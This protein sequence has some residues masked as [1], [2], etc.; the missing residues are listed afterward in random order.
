MLL[1]HLS[2]VEKELLSK[3]PNF[4][5]KQCNNTKVIEEMKVGFQKLIHDV[6]W[7]YNHTRNQENR[8]MASQP[9]R[10][11]HNTIEYP[12]VTDRKEIKLP[13][14]I[15][16]VEGV[17]KSCHNKYINV[18]KTIEKRRIHGNLRPDERRAIKDINERGLKIVASDKG[19]DL[20]IVKGADYIKA[21]NEHLDSNQIY[22]R[23]SLFKIEKLE[24]RVNS[25]WKSVCDRNKIPQSVKNMYMSKCC[26]F[27]TINAV[28][29]TH[30]SS[31]D[32][33]VVRPIVNSIGSP[34]Y[35]LSKF[36]QKVI[37][38]LVSENIVSSEVIMNRI[39]AVDQTT[40]RE[41][42]FPVSLDV[43]SMF[44]NIPRNI[45][46]DFLHHKLNET[47][48]NL[49]AIPP[50]D[51]IKLIEICLRCNH[52]KHENKLYFQREALPMGNR[53]SGVVAEIFMMN[54][55]SEIYATIE[56]PPPTFRYVDD[57]LIFTTG[58]EETNQIHNLYNNN[59]Y[60]LK[61]A[62]ELPVNNNLPFL[63]FRVR[64]TSE[65]SAQFEFFRKSVRKDNFVSANTALP[66]RTI[67]NIIRNERSRIQ[68]R[69]SDIEFFK[70]QEIVFIKR[71]SRN[72]HD[73][74]AQRFFD[75]QFF[76]NRLANDYSFNSLT[77][78][79]DATSNKV[80]FLNI[81]FVDDNIERK[82]KQA[83]KELGVK[84]VVSHKGSQLKH[85]MA[86]NKRESSCNLPN[87]KLKSPLCLLNGSVY[88]IKGKKMW[89]I[90]HWFELASS[91]HTI[92]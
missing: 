4:S 79:R 16:E 73:L 54:F 87:C 78:N 1:Y 82:I 31:V 47:E 15:P 91:A 23:V 46:L 81:P 80:F 61:F 63:D 38:P 11:A 66:A 44:H 13:P 32:S 84:I 25:V 65:G 3:G 8:E 75:N 51:I 6:R 14:L 30:K 10:H 24:E 36:L 86:G 55:Q 50:V 92:L 76:N 89:V 18:L 12:L 2:E 83:V 42:N 56:S 21:I 26:N 34:G 52:F 19:G 71:L 90:L 68:N 64:V 58:L 29:K 43:E 27:S 70:Q 37:Q 67:N 45:A 74:S 49:C 59:P 33:L 62:L 9:R 17:I 72:G 35:N 77:P 69:C 39:K 48:V 7:H 57:L 60:G 41:R 85:I 22:R 88:L 53:L 40:L 28:I 5:V 20:C